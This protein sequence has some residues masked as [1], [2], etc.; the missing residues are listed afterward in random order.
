MAVHSFSNALRLHIF[1]CVD[2]RAKL[3][4]GSVSLACFC[5]SV[6]LSGFCDSFDSACV[7]ASRAGVAAGHA[8]AAATGSHSNGHSASERPSWLAE[9]YD[10]ALDAADDA[11]SGIVSS[12]QSKSRSIFLFLSRLLVPFLSFAMFGKK[13]FSGGRDGICTG[14]RERM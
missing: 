5:S 1:L 14:T 11:G 12:D 2:E 4:F 9:E 10:S 8:G 6:A 7:C 13:I 3:Y